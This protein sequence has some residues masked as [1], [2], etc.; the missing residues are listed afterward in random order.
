MDPDRQSQLQRWTWNR[1]AIATPWRS[2]LRVI[3]Q[4][5]SGEATASLTNGYPRRTSLYRHPSNK[6][7]LLQDWGCL[8]MLIPFGFLG[9]EKAD[10]FTYITIMLSTYVHLLSCW[11]RSVFFKE[12]LNLLMKSC[13]L[14]GSPSVAFGT[15]VFKNSASASPQ[16]STLFKNYNAKDN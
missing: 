15:T 12:S 14:G 8:H 4:R 16:L 1:V 9:H 10:M 3:P 5:M 6:V 11:S 7:R 13:Q 2:N